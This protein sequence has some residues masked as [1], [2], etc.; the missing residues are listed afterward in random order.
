[1]EYTPEKIILISEV[2][3]MKALIYKAPAKLLTVH[4]LKEGAVKYDVSLAKW[5]GTVLS[6][7]Q[8]I[9]GAEAEAY[10]QSLIRGLNDGQK[11]AGTTFKMI[12]YA[13]DGRSVRTYK[14]LKGLEK[15]VLDMS[16][17]TIDSWA[18]FYYERPA[19]Y[20]A[21]KLLNDRDYVFHFTDNWG[22]RFVIDA[23]LD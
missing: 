22:R 10:I 19:G 20:V 4:Y 15:G 1:M 12:W 17:G 5:D 14:S 8:E 3:N 16:G 9:T 6:T 18:E 11:S 13:S 21:N 23:L 2:Y 7:R